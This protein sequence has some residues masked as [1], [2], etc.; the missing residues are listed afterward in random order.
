MAA[1]AIGTTALAGC[2]NKSANENAATDAA[3]LSADSAKNPSPKK[4]AGTKG[5]E[6]NVESKESFDD[7]RKRESKESLTLKSHNRGNIVDVG[8]F[9][10]E[11][12]IR[13]FRV[14]SGLE[15]QIRRIKN[16]DCDEICFDMGTGDRKKAAHYQDPYCAKGTATFGSL[17]QDYSLDA[18]GV[19]NITFTNLEG[20]DDVAPKDTKHVLAH[21]EPGKACADLAR[22][23]RNPV[24]VNVVGGP[25]ATKSE[26]KT[27]SDRVDGLA[28]TV[29]GHSATLAD[30]VDAYNNAPKAVCDPSQPDSEICR[31]G[32]IAIRNNVA[33]AAKARATKKDNNPY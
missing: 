28:E 5:G 33:N 24:R 32:R 13:S 29:E 18:A 12:A 9:G 30:L 1:I 17:A 22:T 25:Y 6:G 27:L 10:T 23:D 19:D 15:D 8:A 21:V 2:A 14:K 3:A 11:G 7:W 20:E 26:V 16:G 4:S 31:Q